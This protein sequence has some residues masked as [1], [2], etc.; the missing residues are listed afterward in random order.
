M[1]ILNFPK[2][3]F[4][5][6]CLNWWPHS[7]ADRRVARTSVSAT[8]WPLRQS[9]FCFRCNPIMLHKS[10]VVRERLCWT[11]RILPSKIGLRA[12]IGSRDVSLETY[13]LFH[14]EKKQNTKK[15]D[16]RS[17]MVWT[18]WI[19]CIRR[20]GSLSS[21]AAGRDSPSPLSHPSQCIYVNSLH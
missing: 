5:L 20:H 2:V 8:P 21:S 15:K 11:S 4:H 1:C 6:S 16:F 17:S 10:M 18:H 13:D 12:K 14:K 7:T 9:C 3:Q 19:L